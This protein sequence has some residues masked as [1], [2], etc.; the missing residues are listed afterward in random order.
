VPMSSLAPALWICGAVTAGCWLAS[1]LTREYS[2]TDRVWSIAP[3]AY[4]WVFAA[5][6]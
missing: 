4:A 2:W 1:V 3:V 5:R 6:A